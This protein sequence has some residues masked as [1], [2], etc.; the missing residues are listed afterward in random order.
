MLLPYIKKGWKDI[1]IATNKRLFCGL[2]AKTAA[3][4]RYVQFDIKFYSAGAM[5]T[6]RV[7]LSIFKTV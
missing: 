7:T 5:K 4:N 1:V 3:F 2:Y 6:L